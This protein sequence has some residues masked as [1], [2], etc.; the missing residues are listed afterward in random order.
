MASTH[1]T[2]GTIDMA[3]QM[4]EQGSSMAEIEAAL[5]AEGNNPETVTEMIAELKRRRH[6]HLSRIGMVLIAAG[7]MLCIGSFIALCTMSDCGTTFNIALYGMTGIGG[8]CIF[9]GLYLILG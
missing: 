1:S 5:I 7:V 6:D 2:S 3:W 4:H 8:T 9:A